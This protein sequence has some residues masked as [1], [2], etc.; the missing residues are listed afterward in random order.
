MI[1]Q[2]MRAGALVMAGLAAVAVIP[3][4]PAQAQPAKD[5]L[6][7]ALNEFVPGLNPSNLTLDELSRIYRTLIARD[8]RGGAWVASLETAVRYSNEQG[9][10]PRP[11]RL[12][13][14][15]AASTLGQ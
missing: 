9:L 5:T 11:M 3:A 1:G 10:T 14:Q 12:D 6:R 13:E 15:F 7:I 8:E 2:M 4:M